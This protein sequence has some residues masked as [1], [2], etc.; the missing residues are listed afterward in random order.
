MKGRL[1]ESTTRE[2]LKETIRRQI[3][4]ALDDAKIDN[5]QL[6]TR[7]L[8]EETIRRARLYKYQKV[9]LLVETIAKTNEGE[10]R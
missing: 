5:G 10:L 1:L 7:E 8:L 3:K 6:A 9:L 4:K 2:I